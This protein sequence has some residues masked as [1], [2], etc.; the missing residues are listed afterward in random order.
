MRKSLLGVMLFLTVTMLYGCGGSGGGGTPTTTQ[1]LSGVAAAGSQLAGIVY[2]VD[3][4]TPSKSLST[5]INA[6]GSYSFDVSGITAPFLLKAVGTANNNNYVFYSLAGGQGTANINPLSNLAVVQA[7]NGSDPG[8]LFASPTAAQLGTLNTALTTA[9]QQVQTLLQPILSQHGVATLNPITDSYTA[10]CTGLD[11][12]FDLISFNLN[13]S[14]L[15]VTNKTTGASILSS[16]LN[17]TALSGTVTNANIPT[18]PSA[19][20]V[21]IVPQVVTLAPGGSTTF[22]AIVVGESSPSITWSVTESG[23]GSVTS[24]GVYTAPSAA[25]TYHAVATKSDNSSNST[26]VVTVSAGAQPILNSISI[27]PAISG[28]QVGDTQQFT[29]TG[30]YSDGSTHDITSSVTWSSNNTFAL[31][32]T[33]GGLA[34]AIATGSCTIKA[35]YGTIVSSNALAVQTSA[36]AATD[37]Y[38]NP[39]STSLSLGASQQL[40]STERLTSGQTKDVTSLVTYK[41]SDTAVA[42]V[43]QAG[44][45]T[46]VGDGIAY[47]TATDGAY[48]PFY[49]PMGHAALIS[50]GITTTTL[51]GSFVDSGYIDGTGTAARF[52]SPMGIATDGTSLYIADTGNN[53]IRKIVIATGK[54]TTLA[55]STSAG[56][57][58]GSGISAQFNKPTSVVTDGTNLYV[59]DVGNNAVRKIE[60]SSGTVS[61]LAGTGASGL[62]AGAAFTSLK[63]SMATDGTNLFVIDSDNKIDKIVIATGATSIFSNV[64]TTYGVYAIATNGTDLFTHSTE[65][66][67]T[68]QLSKINI[69]T[70]VFSFVSDEPLSHG[71]FTTFA[72]DTNN[73]MYTSRVNT[74]WSAA[75]TKHSILNNT[76]TIL[77]TKSYGQIVVNGNS[78]YA[79]DGNSL[80]IIT[81]Q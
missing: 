72:I 1:T 46:G 79:I 62:G 66:S 69:L 42:T 33:Q 59:T 56:Y 36:F 40:A 71:P 25:G 39:S 44:V 29:A 61:T 31:T 34:S 55:G 30:A 28:M 35:T 3:S 73:N 49:A 10:N 45:V 58:N 64:S 75:L 63:G 80:A 23:G 24:A 77:S 26:A 5:T 14:T 51:A 15:T 19:G 27:T 2:L 7:N 41:S 6:D 16:T 43:T 8:T 54:V 53:A 76:D 37:I 48:S 11:L 67:G 4:S 18:A 20:T 81:M 65:G 21:T 47:I 9:I 78:I 32:V 22:R 74:K 52:S 60:I 38:V 17:G 68:D 70:G 50:V 57:V 12:M 13:N